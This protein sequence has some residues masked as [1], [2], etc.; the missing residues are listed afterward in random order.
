MKTA[1]CSN[2]CAFELIKLSAVIA[3]LVSALPPCVWAQGCIASPNNP[4]SHIVPGE[5]TNTMTSARRWSGS[6]SY[7]WFE[8][9][10]MFG[11]RSGGVFIDGDQ[12]NTDRER[13]NQ[14]TINTVNLFDVSATYGFTHRWSGTLTLPFISASRSSVFEHT[15]G[16]RHSMH[17]GGLGDV[18]LT[19]DYWLLDPHKHMQGN[20][21]LGIGFK[22]P[23]GD[24]KA[25][26]ISYRATGPVY[27]PV[28]QSIQPG[29]GG[30]GL[31][32]QLQA[33]QQIYQNLY[34]YVQGSYLI[35][36]KEHNDTQS[37]MADLMPPGPTTY[38]SISDQYFGRGGFSYLVWPTGGLTVSLG[39]RIE[40]VP[41]YDAIGDS[42]GY[43]QPGYTISIEPGISWTGKRNSLSILAPV[44]AYRNRLRSA[45]EIALGR[46]VGEAGFADFSILASFSHRF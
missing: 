8:S 12:E 30:W 35:A 14:Q 1:R 15:D 41:V 39:A 36:P 38:N 24:D 6:V 3:L 33:Y 17:S 9:D 29:D 18:R 43:R 16:Q 46:P 42:L 34:G 10:R 23:T 31:I 13:N 28:D 19:T 44:A 5:F 2:G 20:I 21:A 45:P 27:R 4:C 7:R 40:G 37:V 11:G 22:A 25:S 26:D 32:L